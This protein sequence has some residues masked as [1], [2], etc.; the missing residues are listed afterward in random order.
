MGLLWL[1]SEDGRQGLW[2]LLAHCHPE[3]TVTGG[4][5]PHTLSFPNC[6]IP[7]DT[8]RLGDSA[9]RHPSP[10]PWHPRIPG[11]SRQPMASHCR[12][13]RRTGACDLVPVHTGVWREHR[14]AVE[15]AEATGDSA[16]FLM[17]VFLLIKTFPFSCTFASCEQG[18]EVPL[19]RESGSGD[20]GGRGCI[21]FQML[22]AGV[23]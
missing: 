8:G 4:I 14:R 23:P 22:R 21:Y 3:T 17:F 16:Q 13:H 10:L 19:C 9:K 1:R 7:R 20:S 15:T 5:W 2:Q 18:P 12:P 11:Q 6:S